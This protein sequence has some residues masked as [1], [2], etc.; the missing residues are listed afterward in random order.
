MT[1][2]PCHHH[3]S[4]HNPLPG[5]LLQGLARV[6]VHC[7]GSTPGTDNQNFSPSSQTAHQS[8]PSS[9][10]PAAPHPPQLPAHLPAT[11]VPHIPLLVPRP[12]CPRY[13]LFLGSCSHLPWM[14][15]VPWAPLSVLDSSVWTLPPAVPSSLSYHH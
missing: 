12:P 9:S 2:N 7:P 3:G 14:V 10:H 15:L 1:S 11:H 4:F 13:L 8:P 5:K 6:H